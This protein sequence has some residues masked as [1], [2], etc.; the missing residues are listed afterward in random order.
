MY[1]HRYSTGKRF[2]LAVAGI[3]AQQ[4]PTNPAEQLYGCTV[5]LDL[6]STVL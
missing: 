1:T 3:V 6:A 4:W 2:R 5:V